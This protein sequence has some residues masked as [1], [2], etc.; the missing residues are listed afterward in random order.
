[1]TDQR[2]SSLVATTLV[3]ILFGIGLWVAAGALL[4]D[5]VPL[6]PAE[7]QVAVIP[8]EG[9]IASEERVLRAV[10][11]YR[12][13]ES[14]RGFVVEIRS[15]GGTVGASQS[16]YRALREIREEDDRPVYAWIGDVGA[17]GGY[18]VALGAD[19]IYALPGSITGSIGVI[20]ELPNAQGLLRK[21][22]VEI[23]V[24][25]S[26]AYKDLGSATRP[27][28]EGERE[29]LQGVVDDTYRQFLDV[30]V[31]NRG[32]ERARAEELADGRIFTG[33]Q[34]VE[35]GLV[36]G[37]ATLSETI[38]R[39]GRAAGLGEDPPTVTPSEPRPDLWDVLLGRAG[40]RWLDRLGLTGES[41]VSTPRLLYQ[42]R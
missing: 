40:T 30:V 12:D 13:R 7:R 24:V 14:V 20:M 34:A 16:I 26:G 32:M 27:M 22:G 38:D 21:A 11:R 37:T 10:R 23:E 4:E 15:P 29:I 41:G 36:D 5:G 17:S 9:V 33:A 39:A 42:W 6:F 28:D 1:M 18:Y 2:R 31:E 8:V 19:S 3:L 25:Q 35:L